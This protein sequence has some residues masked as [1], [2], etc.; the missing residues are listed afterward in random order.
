MSLFGAA[1]G[2]FTVGSQAY[3]E[4]KIGSNWQPVY[5]EHGPVYLGTGRMDVVIVGPGTYSVYRVAGASF[6]VALDTTA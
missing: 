1:G 5:D 4:R 2:A 3:L 6:G